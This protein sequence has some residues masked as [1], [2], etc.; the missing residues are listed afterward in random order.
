MAVP[1]VAGCIKII[2]PDTPQFTYDSLQIQQIN[3]N[4][5]GVKDKILF[6]P[7][8]PGTPTAA[9]EYD[10]ET[11]DIAF[12]KPVKVIGDCNVI[13]NLVVS[14]E[15][16]YALLNATSVKLNA[17]QKFGTKSE[18]Y[19][20]DENIGVVQMPGQNK[21]FFKYT[22]A[23]YPGP[24]DDIGVVIQNPLLKNCSVFLKDITGVNDIPGASIRLNGLDGPNPS[25]EVWGIPP[26]TE[27]ISR[28]ML[29]FL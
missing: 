26:D 21:L 8:V 4:T 27:G 6:Q 15:G 13:N 24:P 9:I 25:I 1:V 7:I 17:L 22:A 2:S 11:K 3:T 23:D 12:S 10:Y 5:I 14:D 19:D 28:G 29:L 20:F 16:R 18:P